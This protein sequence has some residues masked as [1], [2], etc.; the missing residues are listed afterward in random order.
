[1]RLITSISIAV[2]C[3]AAAAL[4]TSW[5][6]GLPIIYRT[7][8]AY[9]LRSGHL[10]PGHIVACDIRGDLYPADHPACVEAAKGRAHEIIVEE[11]P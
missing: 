3:L 1:M 8:V 7:P 10:V 5:Y 2:G 9:D 4:L 11:A 6:L